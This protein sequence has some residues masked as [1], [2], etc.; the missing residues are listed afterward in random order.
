MAAGTVDQP[1]DHAEVIE[2]GERVRDDLIG[3]LR[4]TIRGI[5]E[6]ENWDSDND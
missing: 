1:L 4:A 2:V 5:A 3:L 6:L